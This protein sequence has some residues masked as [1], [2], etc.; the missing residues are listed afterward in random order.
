[1]SCVLPGIID[2]VTSARGSQNIISAR[3]GVE[4]KEAADNSL[5][6]EGDV[7]GLRYHLFCSRMQR[8]RAI[9]RVLFILSF[10]FSS[11]IP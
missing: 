3:S 1:M 10:S 9:G 6:A 4:R 7:G 11:F 5:D 8:A 2:T